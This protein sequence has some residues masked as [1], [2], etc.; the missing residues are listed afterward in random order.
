[1]DPSHFSALANLALGKKGQAGLLNTFLALLEVGAGVF[2]HFCPSFFSDVLVAPMRTASMGTCRPGLCFCKNNN[3]TLQ[4]HGVVFAP[5]A[6]PEKATLCIR[7]SSVS[8]L[9]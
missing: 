7:V 6:D 3:A 2:E 1:M 4:D 8:I 9:V 5:G